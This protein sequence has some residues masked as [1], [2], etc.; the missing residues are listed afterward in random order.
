MKFDVGIDI[1]TT[2]TKICFRDSDHVIVMPSVIAVRKDSG[3]I[4]GIGEQAYKMLGKTPDSII[5][6]K[7]VEKGV[8]SDY[9]LNKLLI[10]EVLFRKFGNMFRKPRICLCYHSFMTDLE[11]LTFKNSILKEHSNKLFFIDESF[12][13]ILGLDIDFSDGKCFL[14]VNVG[15]GTTDISFISKEGVLLNKSI[16]IG[17]E[18]IDTIIAKNLIKEHNFLIGK[19]TAEKLKNKAVTFFNPSEDLKFSVKGKDIKTRLPKVLELSQ[20]DICKDIKIPV[21]KIVETICEII[22]NVSPDVVSNMKD[23]GIILT[24]GASL[25]LGFKE[26]IEKKTNISVQTVE[27]PISCAAY[28][29]LNSYKFLKNDFS[30]FVLPA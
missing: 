10:G 4:V 6:K 8:V 13:S 30:Q 5:V 23:A 1:G 3:K 14:S 21:I 29:A 2:N 16:Q 28:G 17:V 22:T 7:T 12:A 25:L 27:D 26:L 19:I 18:L 24:G 15:G 9:L 11:K 20:K